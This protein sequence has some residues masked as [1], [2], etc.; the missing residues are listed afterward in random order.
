METQYNEIL[1][2]LI[3]RRDAL[4]Q[5]KEVKELNGLNIAIEALRGI[6]YSTERKITQDVPVQPKIDFSKLKVVP[7]ANTRIVK[8]P[9]DYN[10]KLKNPVKI[11]FALQKRGASTVVEMVD[12]ICNIDK[13]ANRDK[14]LNGITFAASELFRNEKINATREGKAN[15]YSLKQEEAA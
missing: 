3:E 13:T 6:G 1:K 10:P 14:L 4:L 12:F 5:S 15:R 9:N 11:F 2:P 8:I 7:H